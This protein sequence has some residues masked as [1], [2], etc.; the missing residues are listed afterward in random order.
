MFLIDFIGMLLM[1]SSQ[2][3]IGDEMISKGMSVQLCVYLLSAL[4]IV[5]TSFHTFSVS[6]CSFLHLNR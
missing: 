1:L 5:L 4:W 3:N 2:G 6:T